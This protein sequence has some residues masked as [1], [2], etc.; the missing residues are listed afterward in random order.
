M[1]LSGRSLIDTMA[2]RAL[3][4]RRC[5]L[6]QVAKALAQGLNTLVLGSPGSGRTTLL[7]GVAGELRSDAA[8]HVVYLNAMTFA[9]PIATLTSVADALPGTIRQARPRPPAQDPVLE[10]IAALRPEQPTIVLLDGLGPGV[11]HGLFGRLRDELWQTGIVWGLAGDA[12]R[13]VE[14]PA[15]PADAFFETVVELAPLTSEEQRK[16][17][18]LRRQ[19]HDSAWASDITV[20]SGNPRALLATLR[21]VAES[22]TPDATPLLAARAGRQDRAARLGRLHALV[23]AELEDGGAVSA[24]DR[25]FLARFAI[26]RQRAQQVLSDLERA[27]LAESTMARGASSGRPRKVYY[28]VGRW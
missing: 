10:L 11:A 19:E 14:Y 7:H 1:I 15:P 23:H 27:Q 4:L 2:D 12:D 28:G 24:A 25:D 13:R 16:L 21:A 9:D 20:P 3:V 17:V 26:S 22:G 18:A 5:E 6:P 8:T